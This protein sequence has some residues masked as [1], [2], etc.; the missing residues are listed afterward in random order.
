[1][2]CQTTNMMSINSI[3]NHEPQ[4]DRPEYTI[5]YWPRLRDSLIE[6]PELFNYLHLEC[7]ICYDD[8]SIFP[9]EHTFDLETDSQDE[10]LSHRARILPCGH[11]F[12]S[13]CLHSLIDEAVQNMIP[14]YQG[15]IPCPVCRINFSWHDDCRHDHTGMP[16]PTTMAGVYAM[17]PTFLE[18]GV[19]ADKCGNCQTSDIALAISHL[20]PIF[21]SPLG[22]TDREALVT[23]AGTFHDSLGVHAAYD[24]CAYN[25]WARDVE[26]GEQLQRVCNE[27]I[28]RVTR[29][30]TRYWC[31]KDL[32][33]L[34]VKLQVYKDTR[35]RAMDY[36][37]DIEVRANGEADDIIE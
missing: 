13:K 36:W 21:L 26:L 3:L 14:G 29:N 27:I 25:Q 23:F 7:G 33:G 20:A 11:M 32:S 35:H 34:N 9:H 5:P 18:G 19:L 2:S 22:L 1:M 17:P 4:D 12:G 16:M 28:D 15:A 24:G 31:S 30:K 6:D 8:M 10:A 37:N